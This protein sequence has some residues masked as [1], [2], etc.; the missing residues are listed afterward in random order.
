MV[1]ERGEWVG[2]NGSRNFWTENGWNVSY[3]SKNFSING[4]L[5]DRVEENVM[6]WGMRQLKNRD[7]KTGG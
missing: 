2:G 4:A 1:E 5:T 7:E 6:D 3:L